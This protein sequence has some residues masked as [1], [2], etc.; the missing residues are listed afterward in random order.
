MWDESIPVGFLFTN[1]TME[2]RGGCLILSPVLDIHLR[3]VVSSYTEYVAH[4]IPKLSGDVKAIVGQEGIG[5]PKGKD[6]MVQ[7]YR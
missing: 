7:H 5:Y 1:T 6:P 2:A 3:V 4:L